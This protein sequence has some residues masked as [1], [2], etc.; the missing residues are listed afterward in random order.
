[1]NP[2]PVHPLQRQLLL[3]Q[4]P[5]LNAAAHSINQGDKCLGADKQA[6][7]TGNTITAGQRAH[8]GMKDAAKH[9]L[10]PSV[11]ERGEQTLNFPGFQKDRSVDLENVH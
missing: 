10:C 1:M 11:P 2:S 3:S 9:R 6:G 7:P 8:G 4:E 5:S